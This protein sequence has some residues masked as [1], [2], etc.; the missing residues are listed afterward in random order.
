MA[1]ANDRNLRSNIKSNNRQ[2]VFN[3]NRNLGDLE[4]E[5]LGIQREGEDREY[6]TRDLGAV[7]KVVKQFTEVEQATGAI[8]KSY[9]LKINNY[10]EMAGEDMKSKDE[11]KKKLEPRTTSDRDYERYQRAT[12]QPTESDYFRAF[13]WRIDT[14]DLPIFNGRNASPTEFIESLENWLE[15]KWIPREQ[16]LSFAKRSLKGDAAIWFEIFAGNSGSFE[17]F[18]HKFMQRY[19]DAQKQQEALLRIMK[20]KYEDRGS[21]NMAEYFLKIYKKIKT[22]KYLNQDDVVD[23]IAAH[24]SIDVARILVS[25]NPKSIENIYKT[26][27]R[28]D[29]IENKQRNE[30]H[31]YSRHNSYQKNYYNGYEQHYAGYNHINSPNEEYVNKGQVYQRKY[32]ENLPKYRD[33]PEYR[34]PNNYRKA[35]NTPRYGY[36]T[37]DRENYNRRDGANKW[38]DRRQDKASNWRIRED[39]DLNTA[40]IKENRGRMKEKLRENH[41]VRT[42][43]V[44]EYSDDETIQPRSFKTKAE[45]YSRNEDEIQEEQRKINPS[46]L[47]QQYHC[48]TILTDNKLQ[49][50]NDNKVPFIQG[51]IEGLFTDILVDSGCMHSC[52]SKDFYI[53]LQKQCTNIKS[54]PVSGVTIVTATGNA[55]KTVKEQIYVKLLIDKSCFHIVF[56]VV[57]NLIHNV[58]IGTDF[59]TKF[60]AVIDFEKSLVVIAEHGLTISFLKKCNTLQELEVE[61]EHITMEKEEK[62]E[63]CE[64]KDLEEV[65]SLIEK[66]SN[67]F[68][69]KPGLT[70]AYKHK[71]KLNDNKPLHRKSYPIPFKYQEAVNNKIEEMVEEGIIER[72]DTQYISPIV[73]V[74][75]KDGTVRICLDARELNKKI[76][77]DYNCSPPPEHIL[78]RYQSCCCISTIDLTSSFWQIPVEEAHQKYLGFMVGSKVF[79]FKRVPFGIKTSVAALTCCLDK[80]FGENK[81]FITPYIDDILITSQNSKEHLEHLEYVFQKLKNANMTA[82][83]SKCNF[84][85]KEVKFLGMILS[86]Q[87]IRVD[88]DKITAITKYPRPKNVKQLRAFLGICNYN[89]KFCEQYAN[90]LLP[91]FH[92][93]Q[94]DVKWCW[95]K[96]SDQA[97]IK[98]KEVLTSAPMLHHPDLNKC[99]FVQTDASNIGIGGRLFQYGIDGTEN[100]IAFAS[101]KLNA[102]EINYT[103]SEREMLSIVWCLKKWETIIL[104]CKVKVINDHKALSFMLSCKLLN[105]RIAR[106]ILTIQQF[107]VDIQHCSGK[108]NIIAD[109]LSRNPAEDGFEAGDSR[110]VFITVVNIKLGPDNLKK[111]KDI[112]KFQDLDP[113]IRKIKCLLTLDIS[114]RIGYMEYVTFNNILFARIRE[115]DTWRIFIPTNMQEELIK[116]YH[117][118]YGHY[119]TWKCYG[120][121]TQ[122]F[123]WNNIRR[124]IAKVIARC[125]LCQ[126]AKVPNQILQAHMKSIIPQD[127]DDLLAI[128]IFGPLPS[129]IRGVKYILVVLNVFSKYVK[130]YTLRKANTKSIV[131]KLNSYFNSVTKPKKI[132]SDNATYFTGKLWKEFLQSN[133]ITELHSSKYYPQGNPSERVMREIGRLLRTYCHGKHSSWGTYVEKIEMWINCCVHESTGVAPIQ[134]QE[135]IHPEEY[136]RKIIEFP[137]NGNSQPKITIQL[138]KDR[139]LGKAEKRQAKHNKRSKFSKFEVEDIVWVKAN[140]LSSS[141]DKEIKKLFLIYE[142][143]FKIS[144]KKGDNAYELQDTKTGE[145]KGIFNITKLKPYIV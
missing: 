37:D 8:K 52:I 91:L 103:T 68:S 12:F 71:I 57:E 131:N 36:R 14:S 132:L 6:D 40:Q 33:R 116:D 66:F 121:I 32:E 139:L 80:V 129:S 5:D 42:V 138:V 47:D 15:E 88:P 35:E 3:E 4:I 53:L 59:L 31:N 76:V 70:N 134:L 11:P 128:D 111:L 145:T 107:V 141:E 77:M 102:A 99:F 45:V 10:G 109:S 39:K 90:I 27:E 86:T 56:L 30:R 83:L 142:G 144:A 2:K 93:L 22:I 13:Q 74:I 135:G 25:T 18:R 82:N 85:R 112:A 46:R 78:Y 106:W 100:N 58:I 28:L 38:Q 29:T 113:A 61:I 94:K 98:I 92:L 124:S 126:Q 81:E 72:S 117:E 60:N 55:S 115:N 122:N 140:Q 97:F 89:R 105:S 125:T 73:P 48:N 26:L 84:F 49:L 104:G 63:K 19:W 119:G 136:I 123:I 133:G 130:L 114:Q 17:E 16:R 127:I 67:V 21:S 65:Q 1:T 95:N 20:G 64:K 44:E 41:Y 79:V 87:G 23:V 24:F 96:Q 34:S 69:N 143:P 75:K 108:N 43:N 118:I 7:E 50:K 110:N 54:I 120:V 101:R 137:E 51:K 62:E 9:Q